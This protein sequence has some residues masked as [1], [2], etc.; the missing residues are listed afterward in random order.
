MTK[1]TAACLIERNLA[2]IYGYAYAKLFDKSKAEDLASEILLEILI[3]AK[4]LK[5]EK[6]FWGFAWR[7]AENTF[8]KFIRREQIRKRAIADAYENMVNS[9]IA[10]EEDTT[11]QD[12]RIFRLRRELSL[13]SKRYRTICVSYYVH[14]KS[15][16]EIAQEQN[17]GVETVKQNL[18]KARKLLK[19]GMEME[20]KLGEKSYNPRI[21]KLGFW[22]DRNYYG[23]IC[24]RKLPGAILL[25]AYHTPLTVEELSM[26]LGVAMP[27]LEEELEILEA[28]DLIKKGAKKYET[29]IVIITDEYEKAFERQTCG[30][31]VEVAKSIYVA[32]TSILAKIRSLDFKG[33]D[34]DDMRLL[35]AVLNIAFMQGYDKAHEFS[36]IGQP[37]RLA[38]G[39]NGWVYGYN[40][41]Y[42]NAKFCGIT[43]YAGN[44]AKNAYF[45]AENYA[46]LLSVQN[47][48]HDFEHNNFLA[49][50]EGMCDAILEKEPNISNETLPYLIENKFVLSKGDKVY[51]NFPVFQEGIFDELS[52]LL[53]PISEAVAKCMIEVSDKG[54]AML[55]AGAPSHLKGQ[56]REIAKIYHRL[57]TAAY[58]MET[59]IELGLLV[60]PKEKTPLCVYGVKK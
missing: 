58:L 40:N 43:G 57:N 26:E 9:V 19:G 36:P 18:F 21:L 13:L 4:N 52:K 17:I 30:M 16:F 24:E 5:N 3:S 51:A 15:C 20:R 28:A 55:S 8:R 23:N 31:Y 33:N 44:L 10:S 45:S 46:V 49:K 7:I 54:E 12:E 56:C 50:I 41:N 32:T 38:L 37:K 42:E 34:Y 35:F 60:I 47:F 29:N 25:A 22:G 53:S 6:A 11:E 48:E 14:N 39:G 27:Y 1:E 59:L 2:A